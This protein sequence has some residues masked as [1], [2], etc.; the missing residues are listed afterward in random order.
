[1]LWLVCRCEA[2]GHHLL[3]RVTWREVAAKAWAAV[4]RHLKRWFR[5]V[6]R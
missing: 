3:V 2:C 1:M 4:S 5:F 6:R